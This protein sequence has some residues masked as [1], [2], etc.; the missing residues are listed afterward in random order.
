MNLNGKTLVEWLA[1]SPKTKFPGKGNT[2]YYARFVGVQDYLNQHVHPHVNALAMLQDGGYLTDHGPEHVK[3]VIRRA[4]Q[5]AEHKDCNLSPYE[6]YILLASIHFH[7]VG[8]IFG[9]E[10]H[11]INTEDVMERLGMLLGEDTGEKV[12]IR[13]IGAAH[14]GSTDGDKDRIGR[15]SDTEA[16]LGERI[17][18]RVLA[19]LLRFADELADERSRAARFVMA[20]GQVPQRSEVH[21]K[22]SYALQ[23]VIAQVPGD[24]VALDFEMTIED[25]CRTFGKADNR[26][27]LLD[28][29]FERTM[30]MHRERMYCM[31]F[32]RSLVSIDKINV[33]VRVFGPRYS[34]ECEKI[35]YRLEESGYPDAVNPIHTLCPELT[36]SRYGGVI[37]GESLSEL[38][39]K[40]GQQ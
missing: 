21:H 34:R 37:N 25:A 33:T 19:A 39:S 20:L 6:V 5:L 7:D 36:N 32:L 31:R 23:S 17:R 29:I 15:L 40:G 26:V 18:P 8:N 22:Y 24:S 1:A 38:L 14:G 11:E 13:Q 9:R 4:S 30:K 3:M 16:L 28:E 10:Q 12:A 27:Y 35:T 2:D